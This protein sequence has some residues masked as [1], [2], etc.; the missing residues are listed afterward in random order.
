M[1]TGVR[2]VRVESAEGRTPAANT[3]L[4]RS[5]ERAVQRRFSDVC[6]GGRPHLGQFAKVRVASSNPVVRSR[7][8][9]H[10]LLRR[11]ADA[12]VRGPKSAEDHSVGPPR[13]PARSASP[14]RNR[15]IVN[16][17]IVFPPRALTIVVRDEVICASLQSRSG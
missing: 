12:S 13:G 10:T 14:R 7:I 1:L 16:V 2:Q 8:A 17:C 4:N 5:G 15:G 11:H 6:A 3:G 9:G